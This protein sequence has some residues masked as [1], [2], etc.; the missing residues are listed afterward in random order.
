MLTLLE[1]SLQVHL[2]LTLLRLLQKLVEGL[3][4]IGICIN[5][6]DKHVVNTVS[7]ILPEVAEQKVYFMF[8]GVRIPGYLDSE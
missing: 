3:L 7:L 1:A 5:V 2:L 6:H 4:P 8:G